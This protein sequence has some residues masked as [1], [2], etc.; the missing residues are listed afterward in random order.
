MVLIHDPIVVPKAVS[1]TYSKS[2]KLPQKK[3]KNI[4]PKLKFKTKCGKI[5][6]SFQG[7]SQKNSP[8]K[9]TLVLYAIEN[10]IFHICAKF[11]TPRKKGLVESFSLFSRI[12]N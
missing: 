7:N 4:A 1:T 8:K 5:F 11:G 6:L 12:N 3:K 9:G 2:E 10:F